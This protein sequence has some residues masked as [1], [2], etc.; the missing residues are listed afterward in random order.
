MLIPRIGALCLLIAYGFAAAQIGRLMY[1][2]ASEG[3]SSW[4]GAALFIAPAAILGL[5]SAGLVLVRQP[6][7]RKLAGPLLVVLGITAA[8]TYFEAPPVG[9]FLDDYEAAALARGVEVPPFEQAQ[10]TTPQEW[11]EKE[12]NDVRAQGAI[13]T[14]VLMFIYGATVARGSRA[15]SEAPA[16]PSAPGAST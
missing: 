4:V 15:K 3:Y 13:G 10:G 1:V 16:Q 11:V 12:T 8:M 6:L 5:T 14:I 9:A 7:G 2:V